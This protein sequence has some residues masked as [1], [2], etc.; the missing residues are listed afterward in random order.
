ML[1]NGNGHPDERSPS[2]ASREP[3]KHLAVPAG[4]AP[5]ISQ[6]RK[7]RDEPERVA[8]VKSALQVTLDYRA[9]VVCIH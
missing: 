6:A 7:T 8:K 1:E 9:E 3:L 4:E 2:Y 5:V